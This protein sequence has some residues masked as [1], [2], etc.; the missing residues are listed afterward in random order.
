MDISTGRLTYLLGVPFISRS[1]K[2]TDL[3]AQDI[4]DFVGKILPNE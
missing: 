4:D 1:V 3:A 2:D